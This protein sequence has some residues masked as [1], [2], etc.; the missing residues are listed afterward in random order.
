MKR[1]PITS[2]VSRERGTEKELLNEDH[3]SSDI[4]C[5]EVAAW[6]PDA[7]MLPCRFK[8]VRLL[9]VRKFCTLPLSTTAGSLCGLFVVFF[10]KEEM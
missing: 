7:L 3:F 8:G 10:Q 4:V 5:L 9:V 2:L 6:T 1:G